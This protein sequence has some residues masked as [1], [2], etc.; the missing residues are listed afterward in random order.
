MSKRLK[1]EMKLTNVAK[2]L[3]VLFISLTFFTSCEEE[4]KA[5]TQ[6]A[7]TLLGKW[8]LKTIE[9][10][11]IYDFDTSNFYLEFTADPNLISLVRPWRARSVCQGEAKLAE[12]TSCD[13]YRSSPP[14]NPLTTLTALTALITPSHL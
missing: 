10:D 2:V 4:Q 8:N 3:G 5:T 7:P 11:A 12:D 1:L 6:S 13:V 14:S 9:Y